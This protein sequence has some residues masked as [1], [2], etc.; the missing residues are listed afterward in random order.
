MQEIVIKGRDSARLCHK[1]VIADV[2]L[3]SITYS[4]SFLSCVAADFDTKRS[5]TS[6]LKQ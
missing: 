6:L 4:N 2:V 3:G 1:G 5:A